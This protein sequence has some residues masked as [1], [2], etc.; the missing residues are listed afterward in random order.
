MEDVTWALKPVGFDCEKAGGGLIQG[1]RMRAGQRQGR[2][3][4]RGKARHRPVGL[5]KV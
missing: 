2:V 5:S 4:L 3:G 1:E